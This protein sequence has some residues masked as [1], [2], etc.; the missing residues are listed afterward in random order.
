[1]DIHTSYIP[2]RQGDRATV[3]SI[4][5]RVDYGYSIRSLPIIGSRAL[6][7]LPSDVLPL[8]FFNDDA[9]RK[10]CLFPLM[11]RRMIVYHH[12]PRFTNID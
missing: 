12:G 6:L 2:R 11:R 7:F 1:M 3:Q 4:R 9:F 8:S 5:R 10:C